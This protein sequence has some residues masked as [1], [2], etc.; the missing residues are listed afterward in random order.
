MRVIP[1]EILK[2]ALYEAVF[3]ENGNFQTD[4]N[5]VIKFIEAMDEHSGFD[6]VRCKDCKWWEKKHESN[7]GYCHACKHGHYSKNWEIGI[8]RT[9]KDDWF[10]ADG[11]R[12]EE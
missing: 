6:I 4:I 9:S 10:C 8:Y 5:R 11:E 12:A 3:E 7:Y 2:S 1:A